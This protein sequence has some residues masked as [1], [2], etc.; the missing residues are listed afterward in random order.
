MNVIF[1]KESRGKDEHQE[2]IQFPQSNKIYISIIGKFGSSVDCVSSNNGF[3]R[4]EQVS[5]YWTTGRSGW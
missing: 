2:E 5:S 1:I 4:K 3:F